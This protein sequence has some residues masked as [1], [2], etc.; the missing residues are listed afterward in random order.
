MHLYTQ[1]HLNTIISRLLT[2]LKGKMLSHTN[3]TIIIAMPAFMQPEYAI[4]AFFSF[5]KYDLPLVLELFFVE[6]L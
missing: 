5:L 3:I 4:M 2:S 6:S 1:L